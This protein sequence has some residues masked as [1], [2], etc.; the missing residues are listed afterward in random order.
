MYHAVVFDFDYT[1]GDST[2]GI[3][4]SA[5]YALDQLGLVEKSVAEIRKTIGL[6]LRDTYFAL[7]GKSN[8]KEA[9]LFTR[10]FR[11]KADQVMT[12][13]T[14]LY[15]GVRDSL[16]HLRDAGFKTGIV[17]TKFHYRI[18]QILLKFD[19]LDMVDFI[20]GA[21]DVK[22]E[23]PDPEGLLW[24]IEHLKL[25]NEEVLYVGDSLVDVRTAQNAGV[26]FAG[27][28]T[29]TTTREE[30]LGYPYL[31]IGENIGEI[32]RY[33]LGLRRS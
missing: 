7:T 19:A 29:G 30:F 16:I 22:I 15:S 4:I 25:K 33:V 28:M 2:D 6:S 9:A 32:C 11:E 24:V 14:Q 31:Y 18:E 5:N 26:D 12:A 17:T 3:V 1:L 21:E 10:Y 23:K 20:V 8:L 27:V 13:H